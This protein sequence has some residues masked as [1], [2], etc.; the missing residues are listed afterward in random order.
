MTNSK[1]P[2]SFEIGEDV[3]GLNL[4][5]NDTL[6]SFLIIDEEPTLVDAATARSVDT[7]T[8][9][10]GKL[11]LS[12]GDLSN[13]VVSHIHLDHSG[14]AGGLVSA[15]SDLNVYIHES[16]MRH[17]VEPSRL[18]ESTK[19]VLGDDF[20]EIGAPEPLPEECIKTVLNDGTIIDVGTRSLEVLHTPGHAPDHISVWDPESEV[21]FANE[22]IGRYY[23]MA[24]CWLPP[25]TRPN[26]DVQAVDESIDRL[27]DYE[28]EVVALSHVGIV[29][30]DEAFER[31]KIRLHEFVEKIP[32]WY[33]EM[34][35]LEATVAR[36]HDRLIDLDDAYPEGVV[37]TQ[38]R[39]CTIGVLE[40]CGDL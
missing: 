17:L 11:G 14:A 13:V 26:F 25:V 24:D 22:A 8:E 38:A 19:E 9:E 34:S 30:P 4:D 7:I 10:M 32:D 16:T 28:S 39:I 20:E 2:P 1:F 36:V 27:R 18:I 37:D 33:G 21:L 3:Y 23:P 40:A 29:D 35:D 12:P 6:S 15:G 31:A 5:L